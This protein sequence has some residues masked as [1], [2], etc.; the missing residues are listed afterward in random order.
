VRAFAQPAADG[1]F[2]RELSVPAQLSQLANARGFAARAAAE[3]GLDGDGCYEFAYAVNEAVTN[4]IRHGLPDEGGLIRLSI[5]LDAERVTCAVRDWGTFTPPAQDVTGRSGAG[6]EHG[7]G[8]ALMK[9]LM[10][11]VHLQAAPG[12]TTV[13]LS[14]ARRSPPRAG[15]RLP[16]TTVCP[17]AAMPPSRA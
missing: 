3:C 15:Q 6:V 13:Y 7:R 10:D 4:A 9:K 14:K 11:E 17:P 16:L 5:T 1:P 8:F 2:E 12:G